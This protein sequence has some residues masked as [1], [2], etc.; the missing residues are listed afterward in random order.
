M[1]LLC[2]FSFVSISN[3]KQH[4]NT[5]HD[6]ITLHHLMSTVWFLKLDSAEIVHHFEFQ[7]KNSNTRD[8]LQ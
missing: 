4:F 3:I 2:P 8:R 7:K 1:I 5:K 6:K